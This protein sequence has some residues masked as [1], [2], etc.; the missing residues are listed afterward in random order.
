MESSNNI[1]T[2]NKE[3]IEN[4]ENK[5]TEDISLLEN[6]NIEKGT[7]T[8]QND[9]N[10]PNMNSMEV[11]VSP[12]KR[13]NDSTSNN[14]KFTKAEMH[15]EHDEDLEFSLDHITSM[16]AKLGDES[17]ED[18]LTQRE[19]SSGHQQPSEHAAQPMDPSILYAKKAEPGKNISTLQDWIYRD[20]QG[21]IQG[22][23]QLPESI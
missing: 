21:E 2:E 6:K 18:E 4:E 15:A 14:N 17:D 11:I 1:E 8:V 19:R 23:L 5:V 16:V 10:K 13:G 3:P 9:T 20:P 7:I 12:D 22:I